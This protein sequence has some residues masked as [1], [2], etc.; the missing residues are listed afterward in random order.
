MGSPPKV[1][2]EQL[3]VILRKLEK[4]MLRY[5]QWDVTDHTVIASRRLSELL[6][7]LDSQE[8]CKTP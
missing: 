6:H 8:V 5:S 7:E 2:T 3:V 1:A 4:W